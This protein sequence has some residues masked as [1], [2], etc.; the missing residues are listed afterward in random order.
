LRAHTQDEED[1]AELGREG[2]AVEYEKMPIAIK[3][4]ETGKI[5]AIEAQKAALDAPD[6]RGVRIP[7]RLD[8]P[9]YDYAADTVIAAVSQDPDWE[10]LGLIEELSAGHVDHW[11]RTQEPGVWSGGD[12]VM[13]GIA[14]QA[15]N[16]GLQSALCI[17]AQLREIPLPQPASRRPIST[18]RVKLALYDPCARASTHRLTVEESLRF[19][20][21]EVD[22]G[23]TKDQAA[24]EATRCLSCG[25]CFGCE[26]CWLYCTPGCFR[27]ASNPSLG[28]PYFT[29][30]TSMCDGC[31][32]CADMCPSGFIEMV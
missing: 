28:Q 5:L 32:K 27:K 25:Q 29:L 16:H 26:R 12:N 10:S 11:G 30:S 21:A 19:L 2:I 22:Q 4:D 8:G 18:E 7:R 17:D 15:I 13:L 20:W 6:I 31:R 9:S 23:L 1:L 14:A 24:F 3:R